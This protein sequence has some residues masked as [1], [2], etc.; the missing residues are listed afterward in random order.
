MA[1]AGSS[2]RACPQC[3]GVIDPAKRSD[4]VHCS[5][6]CSNAAW[7]ASNYDRKNASLRAWYA[8]NREAELA[9]RKTPESRAVA[10]ANMRRWRTVPANR[11]KALAAQRAKAGIL[12]PPSEART[13]VCPVCLVDGPLVCDHDHVTGRVRGWP[14]RTCNAAAGMIGDTLEAAERLTAYLR[15]HLSAL[16]ESAASASAPP[17]AESAPAPTSS[18]D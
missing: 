3:G 12:D 13:G 14:C 11:A 6:S 1:G 2:D 10:A 4:A 16:S 18:G 15:A 9:K 5:K 7:R 17:P 8:A